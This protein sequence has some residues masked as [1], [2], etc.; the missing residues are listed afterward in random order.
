[1]IIVG[2]SGSIAA[3]KTIELIKFIISSG[4]EVKIVL[5]KSAE[6]FISPLTLKSLFPGKVHLHNELLGNNDE[7]LHITLAKQANLVLIAPAS[8]N[9]ISKIVCGS[10]DCLLSTICLATKAPIAIAPAM[11]KVMWEND[12]VQQNISLFRKAGNSNK[13]FVL[14]PADGLQACGDEGL[15]R[16]LEP[17]HIFELINN[18]SHPK[19][20]KGKKVLINAGP[21][22]EPIDPVRF[23]SNY[24]S[25]KMGYALAKMAYSLGAEVTLVS[26]PS[27][28]ETP[29]GINIIK[30]ETAKEMYDVCMDHAALNN[31]FIAAAA[32]GDFKI[33]NYQKDKIKKED[34]IISFELEKNIDIIKEVRKKFPS[35]FITGFAAETKNIVEFGKNK[36]KEKQL[37]LIA[38]NDVSNNQVFN[39]DTNELIVIDQEGN[40]NLVP[41]GTKEEIALKLLK[42]ICQKI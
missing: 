42:I 3:Y 40:Q 13:R 1:M 4:Q 30:V 6:D 15:G 22:I 39:K 12:F 21:T 41:R 35:L 14:G 10:A 18:I 29:F 34:N 19:I 20:L 32:V 23:I 2:I 9:I 37:N 27:N 33:K 16:M 25:G 36:L 26:G 24:G 11:N 38:I 7:M 17:N 28:L 8:A 31:V 5:T